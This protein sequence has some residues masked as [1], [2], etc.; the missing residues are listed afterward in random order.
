[1]VALSAPPRVCGVLSVRLVPFG[2]QR[3]GAEL[4]RGVVSDVELTIGREIPFRILEVAIH[5]A[6]NLRD[7]VA[8]RLLRF[9]PSLLAQSLK[10]IGV[11]LHEEF[12]F[13]EHIENERVFRS[14]LSKFCR[15]HGH[16]VDLAADGVSRLP[17]RRRQCPQARIADDEQVHIARCFPRTRRQRAKNKRHLNAFDPTD[18]IGEHVTQA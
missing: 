10:L 15:G 1:M 13:S 4:E 9:K 14:P 8:R 7:L 3:D 12:F 16:W 11:S 6:E 18:R 17:Q 5:H 2:E